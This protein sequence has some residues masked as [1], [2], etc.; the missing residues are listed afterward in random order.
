MSGARIASGPVLQGAAR[1]AEAGA[2]AAAAARSQSA[3]RMSGVVVDDD[4]WTGGVGLAGEDVPG[5]EVVLLQREVVVHVDSPLE[6]LR[7]AGPARATHARVGD[8]A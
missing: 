2:S 7:T 3:R 4:G 8:V 5:V 6:Q 1:T